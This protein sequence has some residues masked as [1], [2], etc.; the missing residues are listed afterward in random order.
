MRAM[1]ETAD[2]DLEPSIINLFHM[3]GERKENKQVG[4]AETEP[5]GTSGGGGTRHL[6]DDPLGGADGELDAEERLVNLKAQN[7]IF[8]KRSR[9]KTKNEKS[10]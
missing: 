6:S 4:G 3:F 8:S 2:D 10:L 1:T 9:K 5:D 7:R